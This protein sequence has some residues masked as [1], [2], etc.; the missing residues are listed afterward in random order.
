MKRII[1]YC[2][3]TCL[4]LLIT[5]S[6]F[7]YP[8][9]AASQVET[10]VL[11]IDAKTYEHQRY[12]ML[13][14][15]DTF[16]IKSDD[17]SALS[18]FQ[19]TKQKNHWMAI[20]K[21]NKKILKKVNFVNNQIEYGK[22]KESCK[23]IQLDNTVYFELEP[24]VRYLNIRL[25][26][27]DGFIFY[28]KGTSIFPELKQN[29]KND[30]ETYE[31]TLS[32]TGIG[33]V[34]TA[35]NNVLYVLTGSLDYLMN[36]TEAKPSI[37][38]GVD[39]KYYERVLT[40]MIGIQEKNLKESLSSETLITD[41]LDEIYEVD[42][43]SGLFNLPEKSE[44]IYDVMKS[45]Y[46]SYKNDKNQKDTIKMINHYLYQY[47]TY[48]DA[49]RNIFP[50][51][52]KSSTFEQFTNPLRQS[53]K[54]VLNKTKD[55]DSILSSAKQ[56]I[57]QEDYASI[58]KSVLESATS[59]SIS[60]S[61]LTMGINASSYLLKGLAWPGAAEQ[62][63]KTYSDLNDFYRMNFAS[64]QINSV[65][66]SHLKDLNKKDKYSAS[67]IKEYYHTSL[68][69]YRLA[70]V[71]YDY[72]GKYGKNYKKTAELAHN[73][74]IS[75]INM[76]ISSLMFDDVDYA[77]T[78][79]S[80]KKIK[81]AEDPNTNKEAKK[82][83]ATLLL[84]P[85][86]AKATYSTNDLKSKISIEETSNSIQT[87][88]F[89]LQDINEDGILDLLVFS[90]GSANNVK[91]VAVFTYQK[92]KVTFI[93]SYYFY[94]AYGDINKNGE[95]YGI[96]IANQQYLYIRSGGSSAQKS[97]TYVT[98]YQDMVHED[99][100]SLKAVDGVGPKEDGYNK[101]IALKNNKQIDRDIFTHYTDE[102][103]S[104][105][106]SF[107]KSLKAINPMENTEA[108]RNA[109]LA[110]P[111]K[112]T[113]D[114][115]KQ[116]NAKNENVKAEAKHLL[117]SLIQRCKKQRDGEFKPNT[118]QERKM[119]NEPGPGAGIS[120]HI[121]EINGLQIHSL[122]DVKSA[123]AD[124]FYNGEPNTAFIE[125]NNNV[126]MKFTYSIIG[127]QQS[128]DFKVISQDNSSA[129]LTFNYYFDDGRKEPN[130]P[131]TLELIKT[132]GSWKIVSIDGSNIIPIDL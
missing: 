55:A 76:D 121:K 105:K 22:I 82:A 78:K 7:Q 74:G 72:C 129:Q 85:F 126:Y 63:A 54:A 35:K 83:Y 77:K 86:I 12:T 89:S 47:N 8:I 29:M 120:I 59:S 43:V 13:Q 132:D 110:Q 49:A 23:T 46:H 103:S 4:C 14:K 91:E 31:I 16:Y 102:S 115:L 119:A 64:A 52:T 106:N 107:I 11:L 68:L 112:E 6:C 58:I 84:N 19:I 28:L 98:W 42:G 26:L 124:I 75:T 92:N 130:N 57:L 100:Y 33:V 41:V 67:D 71:F 118:E 20:Y 111:Y 65:L 117:D 37:I 113:V 45:A 60:F 40:S 125:E 81:G 18:G 25:S 73:K 48:Y 5:L 95:I 90:K 30:I 50:K 61:Q 116:E 99:T 123:Y 51:L 32:D 97:Y 87:S 9:S 66:S 79:I 34:D 94:G 69:Y 109:K 3:V 36:I 27:K 128:G 131:R 21:K 62:G 93:N 56:E 38:N 39:R 17:L 15:D 88:L 101:L 1:K 53:I 96:G 70:E 24:A 127:A 44:I 114:L 104:S 2:Y 122:N 108:N 10:S 80:A